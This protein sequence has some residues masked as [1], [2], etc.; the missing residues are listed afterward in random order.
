M[1][2]ASRRVADPFL[3]DI[4]KPPCFASRPQQLSVAV[5]GS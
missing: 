4:R 3:S 2:R 1:R 5:G